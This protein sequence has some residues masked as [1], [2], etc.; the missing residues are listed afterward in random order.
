MVK[1]AEASRAAMV[2]TAATNRAASG[3]PNGS[4]CRPPWSWQGLG[5]YRPPRKSSRRR[6][7]NY[8]KTLSSPGFYGG[9]TPFSDSY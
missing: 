6:L 3:G 2:A 8:P 7:S 4:R 1:M 5:V 9:Y